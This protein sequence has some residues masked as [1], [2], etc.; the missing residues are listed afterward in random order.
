MLLLF[1]VGSERVCNVARLCVFY[2]SLRAT[3]TTCECASTS[4]HRSDHTHHHT[5][6]KPDARLFGKVNKQSSEGS[7]GS[8][9]TT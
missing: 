6:Y 9:L 2:G 8:L 3:R 5:R 7:E 4:I 1:C